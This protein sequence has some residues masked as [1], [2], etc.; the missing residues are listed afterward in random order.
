M[1][2]RKITWFVLIASIA[3]FVSLTS[4]KVLD[5][6]FDIAKNID[7]F[8]TLYKEVNNY[9]VDEINPNT[10]M[11]T[12]I[13]AM[14][15]SLDPYTS[16]IPEDEIEDY[17]T[18]T[19]GQYGGIG[20]L[21]G[22]RNGKIIITLPYEGFPAHK[23]GLRVNDEIVKIGDLTVTGKQTSDVSK[24]LKGQAGTK[25]KITVKK[26]GKNTTEEI[27]L[28][29]ETIKLKNVP[30]YRMVADDI[31]Y[32]QLTDFTMNASR[33]V[34]NAVEDLKAQGAKKI[35]ID[36]RGNPGGL[37]NEAVNIANLFIPKDAEV[38]KTKGKIAEWNKTYKAMQAPLD[39][40]IPLAV[41]INGRSASASEIVAGVIQD[42]DR[43]VLIGQRTFGKG[44]VQSTRPLSYNSQVKITTAKYYIPSGRCIQAIDYTHRKPDGT[45]GK[46]ADSL[47][48]AFKTKNGRTVYDGAGLEADIPIE[49]KKSSPIVTAL[50]GK[51]L[52]FEYA[53]EFYLKNPNLNKSPKE[54][55]LSDA[56]YN[57]FVQWVK[58]KKI[59]YKTQVERQIEELEKTAKEEKYFDS[60]KETINT[61]KMRLASSKEADLMTFKDEIKTQL[62]IEIATYYHLQRGQIEASLK[63]D[64]ELKAAI[65]ILKDEAKYKEILQAKK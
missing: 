24:L 17:R 51:D 57:E 27:E 41:L 19:T 5:K 36:L 18:M 4:F 33:E 25:V 26:F 15:K 6:Y 21:V 14:L 1:Q 13:D 10:L 54:F 45:A 30:Y 11:K 37:L 50:R 34:K 31:G 28:T 44:L 9:Y 39:T 38:V 65:E 52:L 62:E 46:I 29:R 32:L 48:S 42:Y 20:A 49:A 8:V 3:F 2:K 22:N 40:E 12:G 60:L 53:G 64:E 61:L 16:Y 23:A 56:Q 59:D 63:N 43:G 7:I 55:S 35:I 58:N 47:R